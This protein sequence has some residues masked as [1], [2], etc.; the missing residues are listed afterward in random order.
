MLIKRLSTPGGDFNRDLQR[1]PIDA[2][3]PREFLKKIHQ[4]VDL[5][6]NSYKYLLKNYVD[7]CRIIQSISDSTRLLT[8]Y[9]RRAHI[10]QKILFC[11]FLPYELQELC[12]YLLNAF[13]VGALQFTL[14]LK[15]LFKTI[16]FIFIRILN[17]LTRSFESNRHRQLLDTRN[18]V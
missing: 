14:L 9:Y 16:Y 2:G 4:A 15:D 13:G 7:S 3:E 12:S 8:K 5:L 10:L 11:I 17:V 18:Y 1:S 6:E